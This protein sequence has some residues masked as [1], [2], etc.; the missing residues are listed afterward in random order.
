MHPNHYVVRQ[1]TKRA[2]S[3]EFPL[4]PVDPRITLD[5]ELPTPRGHPRRARGKAVE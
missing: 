5:N 1:M 4:A 3:A 2:G